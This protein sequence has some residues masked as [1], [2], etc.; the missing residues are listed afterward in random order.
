MYQ[1]LVLHLQCHQWQLKPTANKTL[2]NLMA[3]KEQIISPKMLAK[4]IGAAHLAKRWHT[5]DI[6]ASVYSQML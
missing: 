4:I 3:A 1:L 6:Y 5:T 2:L